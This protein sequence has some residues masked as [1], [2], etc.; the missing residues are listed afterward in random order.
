MARA[1]YRHRETYKGQKIDLTANTERELNEKV[2]L[3][4][5]GIDK[6]INICGENMTFSSWAE[7]WL[8]QYKKGNVSEPHYKSIRRRMERYTYPVIGNLKLRDIH[9]INIQVLLRRCDGLSLS[10]LSHI[11]SEISE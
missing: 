8:E 5:N 9:P 6:G 2:R 1:Q 3:R 10:L 7:M 4:K 11:R